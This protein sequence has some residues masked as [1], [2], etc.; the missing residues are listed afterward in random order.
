MPKLSKVPKMPKIMVSL[1]SL[2]F[3]SKKDRFYN[4]NKGNG[5]FTPALNPSRQGREAITPPP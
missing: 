5:H 1:R 4:P 2:D 3:N